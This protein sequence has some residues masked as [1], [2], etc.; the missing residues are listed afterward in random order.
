MNTGAPGE[1]NCYG[2]GRF[3][4][5]TLG[6]DQILETSLI[7]KFGAFFLKLKILELGAFNLETPMFSPQS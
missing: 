6:F 7:L 3:L 5:E 1:I 4:L 2:K